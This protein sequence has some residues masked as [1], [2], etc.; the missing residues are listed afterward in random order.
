MNDQEPQNNPKP[1]DAEQKAAPPPVKT[2]R[3]SGPYLTPQSKMPGKVEMPWFWF[4]LVIVTFILGMATI[5]NRDPDEAQKRMQANAER[6]KEIGQ[7]I[8]LKSMP[9]IPAPK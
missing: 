1:G 7:K 6:Q 3:P 4:G 5:L 9:T 2:R 8:P